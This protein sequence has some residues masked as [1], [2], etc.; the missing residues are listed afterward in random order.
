M[1]FI[2]IVLILMFNT[3]RE[4]CEWWWYTRI[5][6]LIEISSGWSKAFALRVVDSWHNGVWV[7]SGKIVLVIVLFIGCTRPLASSVGNDD[8]MLVNGKGVA[9]LN[10]YWTFIRVVPVGLISISSRH[11]SIL[12]QEHINANYVY[13]QS[14]KTHLI[15]KQYNHRMHF[16]Y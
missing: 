7:K 5:L 9:V 15:A 4:K 16:W 11:S 6:Y 10:Y 1:G 14:Y 13:K 3:S 2:R 12:F 8:D